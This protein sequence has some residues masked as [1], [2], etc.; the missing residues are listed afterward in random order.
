MK[1]EPVSGGDPLHFDTP[2]RASHSEQPL[3]NGGV[4]RAIREAAENC[5][6]DPTAE[7]FNEALSYASDGHLR[8]ARE[9]LAML[10][11]MAPDDGQARLLLARVHAAASQWREAAAALE[12]AA[13]VRATVP[14]ALR[15]AV[16]DNVRGAEAGADEERTAVRAREQGELK[17]LRQEARRLRAENAGLD[18]RSVELE[19]EARRWA[20]ATAGVAAFSVVFLVINLAIGATSGGSET[21]AVAPS[22]VPTAAAAVAPEAPVTAAAIGTPEAPPAPPPPPVDVAAAAA[23]ALAASDA[24]AGTD[25]EVELANGT[26]RLIGSVLTVQ[27]RATAKAMVGRVD[28]VASVDVSAVQL[29][30]RTAGATHVVTKGENLGVIA[31]RYY[32]EAALVKPILAA[33]KKELPSA[34]KLRVGQTLKIPAVE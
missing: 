16:E 4:V 9:R 29:K 10:C 25:L 14:P 15:R 8:L 2:P 6:I 17:A 11:C 30:A 23:S 28:G 24:L 21:S 22:E 12:A 20:W 19:R 33:N 26:A 31:Q 3:P 18:G 32:G 1:P 5:G 34:E 27:Q 7:L 13:A